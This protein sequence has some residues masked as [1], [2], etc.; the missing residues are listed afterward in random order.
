MKDRGFLDE[1]GKPATYT[2]DK[3]AKMAARTNQQWVR[4]A[5]VFAY[6]L[7]VSL[8][9]IILAIY[10]SLI[11]KPTLSGSSSRRHEM[12]V[13]SCASW[14]INESQNSTNAADVSHTNNTNASSLL[15]KENNTPSAW[16][17]DIQNTAEPSQ[18]STDAQPSR[19]PTQEDAGHEDSY[20]KAVRTFKITERPQFDYGFDG[21]GSDGA[22]ERDAEETVGEEEKEEKVRTRKAASPNAE[23]SERISGKKHAHHHRRFTHKDTD[24]AQG[25][26]DENIFTD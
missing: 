15:T 26:S 18:G 10:Y 14:T 13:M 7:S 17:V 6:V 2:G 20:T 25:S 8:A 19:A 24:L 22:K 1:R 11:W 12:S 23:H 3:K 16:L 5:T 4:L 21:S 9:A